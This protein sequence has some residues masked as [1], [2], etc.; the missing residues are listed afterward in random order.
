MLRFFINL[1]LLVAIIAWV[2]AQDGQLQ[3]QW[4]SR[5]FELES[6]SALA[7]LALLLVLWWGLAKCWFWLKYGWARARERRLRKQQEQGLAALTLTFSALAGND[8]RTAQKAQRRAIKLLGD[9]PLAKWLGAEL[10]SR[11]GDEASATTAY[12]ALANDPAAAL[13][14]W[15]GLLKQDS[16]RGSHKNALALTEE[17]LANRAVAKQAFVHDVRLRELAQ[18]GEWAAAVL[19]LHSAESA[20]VYGKARL[21]RLAA[22]IGL[23][24][25]ESQ[26]TSDPKR[27]L[28]S[29]EQAYKQSPDFVPAAI[30][31]AERLLLTGDKSTANK[32][33]RAVWAMLPH[34][35]LLD[36]FI[37]INE[38]EPPIA[39][40][41]RFEQFAIKRK[42][43][44]VTQLALAQLCLAADVYGKARTHLQSAQTIQSTRQGYQLLADLVQAEQVNSTLA[45]DYIRHAMRAPAVGQWVCAACNSHHETWDAVCTSCGALAEVE[46]R[47]T[48][49]G[50]STT[51][52]SLAR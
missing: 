20:G 31:Y 32:V 44:V 18:K 29:L 6:S 1:I 26:S 17:A 51:L 46:W 35:D 12:R 24:H 43:H 5:Y 37:R 34:F 45:H 13:L 39:R 47:D 22:V 52:L 30:A 21:R 16:T 50:S 33:V 9:Q 10:A 15:R 4:G 8:L 38:A 19:A 42:D 27:A 3:W 14:G 28:A 2:T 23:M 7:L 40:L 11:R 48:A 25:A 41:Q 49:V 36:T